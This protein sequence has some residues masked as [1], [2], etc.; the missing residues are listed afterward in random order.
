MIPLS[1]WQPC[2]DHLQPDFIS[3]LH[4]HFPALVII[5]LQHRIVFVT[6]AVIKVAAFS[7]RKTNLERA[8]A[9]AARLDNAVRPL[10][11]RH[12]D[13]ILRLSGLAQ[14]QP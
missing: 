8:R 11:L 4:I 12:R 5:S 10:R 13:S 14:N 7:E 2:F 6:E 3:S 9:L 1:R